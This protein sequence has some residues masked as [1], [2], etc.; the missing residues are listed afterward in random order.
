MMA[1]LA[2]YLHRILALAVLTSLGLL[3][4]ACASTTI[5]NSWT[6]PDYKGPPLKKLMV[7]AISKQ[8]ATR[9][10]FEDEFV[11]E[12]KAAGVDAVASYNFIPED[13]QAEEA[14]VTQAVKE[15]GAQGVL[16]TRFVKVDVNTPYAPAYP[17]MMGMGYSVGYAGAW[18][19]YYDPPMVNQPDTLVLE[20]SLYGVD[21]SHLLWSGTT[22]TFAP[23]NVKQ[24]MQGFAKVIIGA[25]KK[26]K[27]I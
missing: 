1:C 12:L 2:K 10:T 27:L 8:P 4:A 6:S 23:T 13:G 14:R 9:R 15:S 7:V 21:E 18:G 22:E 25:L 24:E 26:R 11:K 3:L 20:T 17:G 16:I 19:S 5:S